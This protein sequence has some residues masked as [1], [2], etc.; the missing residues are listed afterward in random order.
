MFRPHRALAARRTPRASL[1]AMEAPHRRHHSELRLPAPRV[2]APAA[3]GPRRLPAGGSRLPPLGAHGPSASVCQTT[4]TSIFKRPPPGQTGATGAVDAKEQRVEGRL[5]LVSGEQRAPRR[6]EN[7]RRERTGLSGREARALLP[8]Q[9]GPGPGR[10][11]FPCEP[12][13][14]GQPHLAFKCQH[15]TAVEV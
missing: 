13:A 11:L 7:G 15:L 12:R 3:G 14:T 6:Q 9:P 10:D 5:L 8:A 2:Q 4:L 1:A